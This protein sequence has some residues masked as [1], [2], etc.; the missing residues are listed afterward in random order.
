MTI[1]IWQTWSLS[2]RSPSIHWVFHS[3]IHPSICTFDEFSKGKKGLD[4]GNEVLALIY[5][6]YLRTLQLVTTELVRF[7][8][9]LT[10]SMFWEALKPVSEHEIHPSIHW[11][12]PMFIPPRD[13]S[14]SNRTWFRSVGKFDMRE[15]GK[16]HTQPNE[17]DSLDGIY[18]SKFPVPS[19]H[20]R[21]HQPIHWQWYHSKRTNI[22]S[23]VRWIPCSLVT[24]RTGWNGSFRVA[25]GEEMGE[26]VLPILGW[27][28]RPTD[29]RRD[30]KGW[31]VLPHFLN[32]G[33]RLPPIGHI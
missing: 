24:K 23:L 2:L 11:L 15:R 10:T 16:W 8:Q 33:G 27:A 21:S 32:E 28:R 22:N 4:W 30:L 6:P 1:M 18:D 14:G 13:W 20:G 31:L 12:L 29:D 25:K 7:S 5:H 26:D 19:N 3:F 17:R 9:W